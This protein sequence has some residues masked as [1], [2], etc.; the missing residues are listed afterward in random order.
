MR[1]LGKVTLPRKLLVPLVLLCAV[2]V[3]CGA[4]TAPSPEEP[5]SSE[6]KAAAQDAFRHQW[7]FGEA[8]GIGLVDDGGNTIMPIFGA[9]IRIGVFD[10]G[11]E[12]PEPALEDGKS[13]VAAQVIITGPQAEVAAILADADVSGFLLTSDPADIFTLP[14]M[15]ECGPYIDPVLPADPNWQN[16]LSVGLYSIGS[17]D[18]VESVVETVNT[19]AAGAPNVSG[20]FADPNYLI[21]LPITGDPWTVGGSPWTV[22]GSPASSHAVDVGDHMETVV[23]LVR[24]VAPDSQIEQIAVLDARA[25]GD[26]FTLLRELHAFLEQDG[27][28]GFAS[29]INLSLGVHPPKD[30]IDHRETWAYNPQWQAGRSSRDRDEIVAFRTL[31]RGAYCHGAVVLAATGNDSA[32]GLQ[33]PQIPAA[34]APYVISVA[35]VNRSGT[36][37]CF[38]N[39]TS[40][41]G[42]SAPGGEGGPNG[43]VPC[44]SSVIKSCAGDCDYAVIGRADEWITPIGYK[45]VAGTSFATPMVSGLAALILEAHRE[46]FDRMR[47]QP[48]L[49]PTSVYEALA[50]G[51]PNMINVPL[52]VIDWTPN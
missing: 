46:R 14:A 48:Y 22:G 5:V 17:E 28:Y 33:G 23:S 45:Y 35:A 50:S 51:A 52:S 7:A 24:A 43:S 39:A 10:T 11:S 6:L 12:L 13:Y 26:L 36:R 21:G 8:E 44:D 42:V 27:S 20:V 30:W 32:D 37:S 4:P 47:E 18:S 16:S 41:M 15:M 49:M 9:G 38:S 2:T 40:E 19:A 31:L 29:I 25:Q 1:S 3:G 34:W